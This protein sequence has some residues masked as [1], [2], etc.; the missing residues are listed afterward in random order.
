MSIDDDVN[1]DDADSGADIWQYFP[2]HL[3]SCELIKLS[4]VLI[5]EKRSQKIIKCSP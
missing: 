1:E 2:E 3:C 5:Y 4:C